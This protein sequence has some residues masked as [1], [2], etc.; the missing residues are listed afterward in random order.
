[1]RQRTVPHIYRAP[2][3]YTATAIAT[4]AT[5]DTGSLSATV[6]IG[7]LPVTLLGQPDD[8]DVNRR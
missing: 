4:D 7:S 1:M 8:P 5:G 2:G 6:I 3:I